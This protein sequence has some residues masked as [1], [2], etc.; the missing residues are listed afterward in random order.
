MNNEQQANPSDFKY[1][2]FSHLK[3][4]QSTGK[5]RLWLNALLLLATILTTTLAGALMSGGEKLDLRWFLSGLHFSVPLLFILG[6]HECGHYVASRI[7]KIRATLPYF[8]PAPTLIGTFG[9]F[10]RIKEPI[11]DRRALM[12]IGAAG[13]LAG[14]IAAIPI[15]IWGIL[16]SKFIATKGIIE[17]GM[18]LGES[19][20]LKAAVLAIWGKIP[21]GHELYLS[22]P[23][24]AA[25]LGFFVTSLNLLPVGQL[26][27]GHIS[28]ALWGARA[29]RISRLM[30]L[31]LIPLG[32]FWL[33]WLFWA[34]ILL[35]ALG[36]RHPPLVDAAAPLGA[37]RAIIGYV[38]IAV[39]ILTFTPVPFAV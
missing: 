37:K 39:F 17:G 30:F 4:R 29:Y 34:L 36:L 35:F 3:I 10:I 23:A 16:T 9:A 6:V 31:L 19:L 22:S 15:M 24:F 18:K 38:C 5:S 26:D 2:N 20:M 25:W 32:F 14:F 28:C 12:D 8:I 7:H 1:V 21:Q 33:G 27:G 11:V 13:P